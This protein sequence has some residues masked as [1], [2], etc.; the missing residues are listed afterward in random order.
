V[1]GARPEYFFL[2]RYMHAYAIGWDQFVDTVL[3]RTPLPVT[4][5]DGVNALMIA[6]AANASLRLGQAVDVVP[7]PPEGAD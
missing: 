2:E 7:G 1:I 5:Q 6:E 3:N 4:I